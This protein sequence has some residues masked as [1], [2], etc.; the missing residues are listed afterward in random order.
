[1]ACG[2]VDLN[3]P[4]MVAWYHDIVAEK[5]LVG[6]MVLENFILWGAMEIVGE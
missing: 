3:G 6:M 4:K 5:V 2:K 1:M